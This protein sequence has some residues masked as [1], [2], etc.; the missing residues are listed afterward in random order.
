[1]LFC[2]L[3]YFLFFHPPL[4]NSLY[5]NVLLSILVLKIF[6]LSFLFFSFPSWDMT[7]LYF[8]WLQFYPL[9]LSPGYQG[10]IESVCWWHSGTTLHDYVSKP[11]FPTIYAVAVTLPSH[12]LL[13]VGYCD[14]YSN[15]SDEWL[16]LE[17]SAFKLSA[18]VNLRFQLSC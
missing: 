2:S 12:W 10:W 11:H 8:D 1:M 9:F 16:T 15:R 13:V 3:N 5:P 18:V 4:F 17:T 14:S 7:S 6:P